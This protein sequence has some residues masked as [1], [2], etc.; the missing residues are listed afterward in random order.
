MV[1]VGTSAGSQGVSKY[2]FVT[3]GRPFQLK[4][5]GQ[6][7]RFKTVQFNLN[8]T[9]I[10]NTWLNI[11]VLYKTLKTS[12]LS[13]FSCVLHLL[14]CKS[15]QFSNSAILLII[16]IRIQKN[17]NSLQKKIINRS[18]RRSKFRFYVK[19]FRKQVSFERTQGYC[20]ALLLLGNF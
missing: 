18:N 20:K 3:R 7:K 12:K 15:I 19:D 4:G 16:C 10:I 1:F 9:L 5:R 6:A 8:I 14:A 2:C 13:L 11:W 17:S